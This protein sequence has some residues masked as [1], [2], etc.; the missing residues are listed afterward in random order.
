[1]TTR[2]RNVLVLLAVLA[3]GALG[4][5]LLGPS[6]RERKAIEAIP[7]G[8]FLVVTIDLEKGRNSPLAHDLAE[9]AD[10]G[11]MTELCGFDP[12]SHVRTLAVGVP[13]KP[14]GV[15]GIA[16]T[17]DLSEDDLGKCAQ[18]MMSLRSA[19]PRFT[20][21]GSWTILE[22]EGAIAEATRAKI[23]YRSGS[24]VLLARGDYL[25]T[26]QS[27][28]DGQT[29]RAESDTDH[30]KLRKAATHPG[31]IAI[32]TA[33]LPKSI[34]DRIQNEM[35][36]ETSPDK[37]STM[38][39]VLAVRTVT[40]SLATRGDDIDL[41]AE[42]ECENE[43][44]CSTLRDFVD[45]KRKS[46]AQE[47]AARFTGIAAILDGARA[48]TKGTSLD[49]TLSAAEPEMARAA[50]AVVTALFG[51]PPERRGIPTSPKARPSASGFSPGP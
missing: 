47:P 20:Q 42:L 45:K 26:M 32:A 8:A 44:A 43:G 38:T 29:G 36:G 7:S 15:F 19:T 30:E 40:V 23:A 39:A 12:V 51:P 10:V 27:A 13:E 25:A 41:F 6:V 24:P 2:R 14:D 33:V 16:F 34:R 1:M 3:L 9:L 50:R 35:E 4:A 11:E 18:R 28:L 22:Q 17:H 5:W 37:K 48:E 31:T 21:R 49:V 46:I